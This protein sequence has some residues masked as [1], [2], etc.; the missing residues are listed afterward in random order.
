MGVDPVFMPDHMNSSPSSSTEGE[1]AGHAV[2]ADR[3]TLGVLELAPLLERVAGLAGSGPGA[4]LVRR[5]R[6]CADLP[7]VARRLRRLSQLRALMEEQ[8]RPGL[9]GLRDITP[10][11]RRL[12]VDGVHLIPDELTV[13]ADFLAAAGRAHSFL[14][15]G[16]E[17]FDELIR[18][19]N[20]I[21]PLPQVVSRLRAIVGPGGT[22]SSA[23]SPELGRL[24]RQIG[25]SRDAL[26]GELSAMLTA[27][28]LE[29]AFS[30]QVVTQRAD[31][32]VVP[33]R[34]GAKGRVDGIIHD[35]SG[36]GATCFVE[37]LSAVE[38]NNRLAL[39]R[40]E[41]R[42]EEIRVLREAAALLA[43]NLQVLGENLQ[44][45]AKLDCLL[46]QAAFAQRTESAEPRLAA[47]GP[48]DFIRARH[49]LLAW[50]QA[51][52]GPM[53]VPIRVE[54]APGVRVLVIS[55]ANAG[56]KTATLKTVGLI[57]LMVM[58]G[59]HAPLD[60]ASRVPVFGQVLAEVGDDQDLDRELSSFTAHAGRLAEM[61]RRADR[62]SLV[63]IDEIGAGTDPGE[64]SALA[65]AVL[66]WFRRRGATV[67]CTTHFQRL[68]AYGAANPEAENVSVA[69]DRKTGRAT[70]QLHYGQPGFSNALAVAASLGF[71]Q[72]ILDNA[73]SQLDQGERRAVELLQQAESARQEA[74]EQRTRAAGAAAAAAAD[75]K[76]AADELKAARRERSGAL[77]EGK[78]RVREVARRMEQRLEEILART[79]QERDQGQDPKPGRVRQELYQARREAFAQVDETVAEKPAQSN[80]TAGP[81]AA[82]TVLKQGLTVKVDSLDQ[83]GV[84]LA[85][86]QPGEDSVPVAVGPAGVRFMA[87]PGDLTPVA[88][89]NRPKPAGDGISVQATAGDGLDLNLVGL[90]VEEALP[91]VD[92]ALDRALLGGKTSINVVHGVGTGRLRQAV[93]DYLVGHP[94]VAAA[95]PGP[96][97][98]SAGVTVAE[99]RH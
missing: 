62:S 14:T 81:A 4:D 96:G 43:G 9:D 28:E 17:A 48:L 73:A 47:Q 44:S 16:G 53:A 5:L 10:L 89:G 24:R 61:T 23:A 90:T 6:P 80:K 51:S 83:V 27:P 91:L 93:R 65:A 72:A 33:V 60:P 68:K 56:G 36:S 92:K 55:G 79:E 29:G 69:F 15:G 63:L 76:K 37:P 46:A 54:M 31:R 42:E 18:L 13:M 12:R 45:L 22:V 59:L 74:R 52:G 88:E 40:R 49:P 50:R 75:R 7:T 1:A 84:L 70:Y 99:L 35:Y 71:D 3:R 78:R 67:L 95:L 57:T 85:D 64:G 19:A 77:A 94:A 39:L 66:D 26:R 82:G 41:E 2:A 87:R 34:A 97:R 25:R 20:R 30:D 8:G 98:Q 32:F 58:C 11:L 38:G 21:T 86:P